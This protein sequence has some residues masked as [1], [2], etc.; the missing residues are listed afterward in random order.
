MDFVAVISCYHDF[1]PFIPG[2]S[3]RSYSDE[4]LAELNR[5][6]NIP[7]EYNGRQYTK[8]EALQRQ[9][10][11]ETT[12]R[13]Q[14]QQIHLLQVGNASQDD[15]I[16]ARARYR[17]TS[18]EYSLFSQKMHLPQQRER[19]TVDGLGNI[20]QG[21]YTG[22]SGKPSP[23][24]VPKPGAHV[25]DTVTASERSELL[26]HPAT[27]LPQNSLTN[28]P[29]SGIINT[30]NDTA[31]KKAR[32]LYNGM[33]HEQRKE[34]IQRGQTTE[35]PVFSYDTKENA[36][37]SNAQKIPKEANAFD[38]IAHGSPNSIEFFRQD[39]QD[40]RSNIDAYT[41]SVIL[42]G[43]MDYKTFISACKEKSVDPVIRLL[44]CN[45]G[46]TSETGDCFAQ[47]LANELGIKVVAPTDTIYALKN[48][49]FYVGDYAD[50]IMKTFYPRK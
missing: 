5:Q 9:R 23:V 50:G 42:K 13:A 2:I 49:T 41:L 30:D 45:T 28:P 17:V 43:R 47:L 16:N 32:F 38:V 7:V 21:K 8:Y 20:G 34:V 35:K 12:M 40:I 6:E 31:E 18:H 22:G 46:N 39:Y 27:I 29:G 24:R 33:N 15:L 48:G 4:E 3:E 14:R 44:A 36:F 10:K 26:Q 37:P 19:V 25:S 11:L 1:F